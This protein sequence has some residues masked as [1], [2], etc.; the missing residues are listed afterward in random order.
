MQEDFG[1]KLVANRETMGSPWRLL[2]FG[3]IIL[4][5]SHSS[6]D[7]VG[8][9]VLRSTARSAYLCLNFETYP[10]SLS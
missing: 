8:S 10:Y 9:E 3:C 7:R 2:P 4:E 6:L 1:V 5:N